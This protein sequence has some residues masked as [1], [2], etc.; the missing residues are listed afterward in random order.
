MKKLI[1]GT[2]V[3]SFWVGASLCFAESGIPLM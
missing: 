3:L 2:V 1:I